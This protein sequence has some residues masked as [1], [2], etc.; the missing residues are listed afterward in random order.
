MRY[1]LRHRTTY[2]YGG[3]VTRSDHRMWLHPRITRTQSVESFELETSPAT[4]V[5]KAETDYFG[6]PTHLMSIEE[7]HEE[8]WVEAR[9]RVEVMAAP[10]PIGFDSLA[11]VQDAMA[12]R[13]TAEAA[14]AAEYC[15]PTF[16]STA[17]DAIEEYARD[18][19]LPDRS[20]IEAARD[21][22]TRIFTE[23]DYDPAAT[24]AATS[25]IESFSAKKGVCQDFA[26]VFLACCRT[27]GVP[28]RYVSG[29]LLTRPPEGQEKLIGSDASHAWVSV[30]APNAGWVDFDP[31]NDVIPRDEHITTAWGRD[32]ADVSP[33]RGIVL[34]GGAGHG[35]DVAVDVIPEG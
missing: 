34:G 16:Y 13:D 17:N 8:L 26:H 21:L 10:D 9:S 6:N 15:F 4:G 27:V 28:A 14:E 23:F 33:I 11:A 2:H 19:F 1:K 30:W 3:P 29:Y 18:V 22:T 32:F 5:L 31:T 35:I 7:P 12:R 25:G 24:D 20:L